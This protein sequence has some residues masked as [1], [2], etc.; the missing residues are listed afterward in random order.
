MYKDKVKMQILL[1]SGVGTK[2]HHYGDGNHLGAKIQK[3]KKCK[4][5]ST[6]T[7]HIL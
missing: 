7:I 4:R 6:I 2:I 5:I 3:K 1:H